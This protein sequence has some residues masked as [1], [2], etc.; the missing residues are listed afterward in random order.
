MIYLD[1]PNL[2]M[3]H[4]ALPSRL[5]PRICAI[6]CAKREDKL[7]SNLTDLHFASVAGTPRRHG[8]A[9]QHLLTYPLYIPFSVPS[10]FDKG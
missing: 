10:R 4:L 1:K 3:L 9:V 5:S 6:P 2:S 7:F 8:A